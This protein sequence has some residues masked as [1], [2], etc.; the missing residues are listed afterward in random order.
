[1]SGGSFEYMYSRAPGELADVAD[2]LERMADYLD[3]RAAGPDTEY[4]EPVDLAALTECATRLRSFAVRIRG[5]ARVLETW[6]DVTR[7]IEWWVS[8]DDST[9]DVVRAYKALKKP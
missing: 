3:E 8:G 7:E 1:M 9:A 2:K 4:G 5:M 6:R